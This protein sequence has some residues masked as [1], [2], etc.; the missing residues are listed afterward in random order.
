MING[1]PLLDFLAPRVGIITEIK[2]GAI[3]LFETGDHVEISFSTLLPN[4]FLSRK[5]CTSVECELV[6]S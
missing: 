3:P 6:D 2:S 1:L 5:L 4:L